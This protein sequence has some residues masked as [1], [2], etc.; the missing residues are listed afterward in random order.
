MRFL[1]LPF[2]ILFAAPIRADVDF[3]RDV[4]PI[5]SDN[6]FKCHGPDEKARKAKLRLDTKDGAKKVLTP[7][8]P[9]ESELYTRVVSTDAADVM[10]PPD[11]NLT[12][13]AKQKE[14][15]KQW[16]A[17]GAK[18]G[19]HWAYTALPGKVQVPSS[20]Y[21][22]R[23]PIDSFVFARLEKEGL[24][25][26]PEATRETWLR[27]VTFDLTGLPP[28]PAEIAAFLKDDKPTAY[29]TVVD[30]LLASP[31]YGER[32]A[33]D[34]LDLARFADTH[35]YQYDRFRP[36]WPYRDWVIQAFNKNQPFDQFLTDQ[37]AGDLLPNPTKEQRLAT[38]FNRL[39]MQNEEGGVVEE[40]FRVAYV[41]DRV[42]TFGTAFLG[43]TFECSRCHDHKYDPF[44]QKDFYR[45]FAF[46]QNIDECGQTTYFT[47][48][49]PVPTLLLSTD[50]QDQKIAELNQIIAA[51]E[52]SARQVRESAREAFMKWKRPKEV[53]QPTPVAA[54]SFDDWKDNKVANGIDAKNPGKGHDGPKQTP[55]PV[56]Q[57]AELN[58]DNGFE[59]PGVGHFKRSDP[60]SLSLWVLSPKH[61]P[62][63]VVVHHSKAPVDA[64]S[65]GYELLLED[66]KVA[67]GLHHMWP[68]NSLKVATRTPIAANEWVHVTVTYDGSSRADGVRVYVNGLSQETKAIRDKL[69]KDIDYGGGEPNLAIGYRFRDQGFKGG[70]TDEFRVFDRIL[71]PLEAA[72]LAG[73]KVEA[74]EDAWFELFL[75][76]VHEPY[77]K[78]LSEVRTARRTL[79]DFVNPIPEVM[80]MREEPTPKPAFVLKRGAYDAP[81]EAVSADTP[82]AL[83][84]F[85]ADLPRNRLGLARWLTH[86]DHP[87][88][89]RV[90][91]NRLWQQMFGKGLVESSDNFG[92]TGT[93]PTHPELLDW[94]ARDFVS[95]SVSLAPG[96]GEPAGWDVKRMLKLMALS[97]T[98][99]QASKVTPELL[100]KDPYN[101]LLARA[102]ARRLTAEMLRDQALAV[103]GLLV[104]KPGG[105]SVYPYQPDGLWDEA[106]GRPKYPRSKGDDLYRRSLYTYVKRTVPHP[107][108]TTF[109]AADRSICT[110]KRQSTSTPLQAL[111]LL[112][113][114]QFVEAGRFLGQRML[115]E[116]GTTTAE[117]AGWAFRLVTGRPASDKEVSLLVTLFEEQRDHF[118]ANP[119]D[120]VKLL[121][122]GESKSDAKLDTANLAAA[123]QLALAILNHDAAVNRR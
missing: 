41:V 61:A 25:P 24:K 100:A 32:M 118:A 27:R 50:E 17:E 106:M 122:I 114:P 37:L 49:M 19:T 98:Y 104:E 63:A 33:A 14:T 3:A 26:S 55:G 87:L 93:P 73:A 84:A 23:N 29:E 2:V 92:T 107:Q 71:T 113:D 65:R 109:D 94:L 62:R 48:A 70:K 59:F 53:P 97:A 80:V 77:R 45:L 57:G 4:L 34:W 16:V 120:V 42:N 67:F 85:P 72:M 58:G 117:R 64:G 74:T 6:C 90:T 96:G 69:T 5:L 119:K 38:A 21:Q 101:H 40:E 36:M 7:G 75:N 56:G 115:K 102:P 60:F 11:S 82:A 86:P 20:K 121:A 108:M 31:R 47:N 43:Q 91:V 30:R 44:T 88:T 1:P 15:L 83:P 35:G 89:A 9:D 52:T 81:G 46:F 12:L 18:W 10:P 112:N 68:G 76:T 66:G 78:A 110:A 13:T 111:A 116:G 79:A 22:T 99:R 95:P 105:P 103:S 54:Y 28:T 8:K 51:S 123:T 39:H